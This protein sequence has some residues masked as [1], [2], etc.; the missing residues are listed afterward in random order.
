MKVIPNSA[1]V[2]F[3]T[4]LILFRGQSQSYCS[5]TVSNRQ[6]DTLGELP[7]HG[8]ANK[9]RLTLIVCYTGINTSLRGTFSKICSGWFNQT[10]HK[11]STINHSAIFAVVQTSHSGTLNT[12]R[13]SNM[14]KVTESRLEGKNIMNEMTWMTEVECLSFLH[15]HMFITPLKRT[16]M[17]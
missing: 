8:K 2:I 6:G 5:R 9:H 17:F 16:G 1:W 14:W 11:L 3:F 12:R 7:V 4:R 10:T 15:F 13:G